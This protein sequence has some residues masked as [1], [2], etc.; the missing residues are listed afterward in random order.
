[1]ILQSRGGRSLRARACSTGGGRIVFT[2]IEGWPAG[3][4]GERHWIALEGGGRTA[5]AAAALIGPK[6]DAA[7]GEQQASNDGSF[8]ECS[9]CDA[10]SAEL[11]EELKALPGFK[12]FWAA[13]PL[14]LVQRG[15]PLF[16]SA[17]EMTDLAEKTGRSLGRLGLTYEAA[18]LGLPEKETASEM[19]HRLDVML[20]SVRAGFDDSRVGMR[21]LEPS[22]GR[23][24]RAESEGKLPHGGIHTR[25]AARAMAVMHV[26][27]SDGVLCAAPTAGGGGALPGVVA[28]LI[29]EKGLDRD[30][31]VSALFAAG[32]VGVIVGKRATFAAEEAGCQVEI[33]A[34]GAMAAAAVVE[35]AGGSARQAA[36]AAAIAFQNSMGSVCDLVQGIVEVPCHT[37]NAAAAASAFVLADL[38]LGGYANA[39]PF[40]ETID[41][42]LAVGRMLPSELRCTARGGLAVAPSA[43]NMKRL[44]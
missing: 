4:T 30:G 36:D 32:A 9:F 2:S 24:L 3:L 1:M 7:C 26:N 22:A 28:T 5:A 35:A 20:E 19:E 21:L 43:R 27:G 41:A 34:A 16:S 14:F 11:L 15:D 25:A 31:A 6:P 8:I 13:P 39:I 37:R 44:R 38:V 33:G 42:V 29:E 23:I 12:R 10:P 18:L 17:K 40:D